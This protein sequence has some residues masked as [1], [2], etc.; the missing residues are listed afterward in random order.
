[1]RPAEQ[2]GQQH[3]GLGKAVIVRLQ[4]GEDQVELLI[5]NR[6]SQDLGNVERIEGDEAVIFK[7]NGAVSAFGQGFAQNLLGARRTGG[8]DHNF[9]AVLLAL[10]QCLFQSVGIGFV[11]FIRNVVANPRA[12]LV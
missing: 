2:F 9:A 10:A 6:G 7:V 5:F 4:A 11:H 3:A 8:D 1:M 12:T